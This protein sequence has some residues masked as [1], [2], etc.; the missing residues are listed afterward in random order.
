MGIELF[1]GFNEINACLLIAMAVIFSA[2]TVRML[3]KVKVVGVQVPIGPI[4]FIIALRY[5]PNNLAFQI[6]QMQVLLGLLFVLACF[7]VFAIA[8]L[9]PET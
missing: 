2:L 5:Y 1:D 4:A 7:A 8:K 3:G 9:G 6:G